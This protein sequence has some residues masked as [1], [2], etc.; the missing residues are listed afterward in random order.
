MISQRPLLP[1]HASTIAL[2]AA[3]SL[4]AV[5]CDAN[6][7]G[8][9]SGGGGAGGGETV[10]SSGAVGQ[11]GHPAEGGGAPV[12]AHPS[13]ALYGD[14]IPPV[15]P[16]DS[17]SVGV[18]GSGPGHDPDRL[19]LFVSRDQVACA[20]PFGVPDECPEVE[21]TKAIISL[22]SEYQVPGTYD[23]DDPLIISSFSM[24]GA[25]EDGSCYGG[26]G[27][28]FDGTIQI[29]SIDEDRVRLVLDGTS[30]GALDGQHTAFFCGGS[31]SD[32]SSVI[33]YFPSDLPPIE[34]P[35]TSVATTGGGEE[36]FVIEFADHAQSCADPYGDLPG[37]GE[38]HRSFIVRLPP[39]YLEPGTYSLN[40]P[41]IETGEYFLD[42]QTGSVGSGGQ[43]AG[44]LVIH[45]VT[46]AAI[47]L[48]LSGVSPDFA[49]VAA[50]V[51]RC[52]G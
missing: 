20:S 41:F 5:G 46:D 11:G 25:N 23:L 44:T 1:R 42:S 9:G 29:V 7:I 36:A 34:G 8:G 40:D 28:F 12:D 6:P 10:A 18:G 31:E 17:T 45:E 37:P 13:I 43:G 2:L 51:P 52:G 30:P 4:L 22:P 39:S 47:D 50:V 38:T 48:E 3:S 24:T 21:T 33:G 14:Q 27:S 32:E 35:D 26:G 49:N 16:G 19:V 15:D